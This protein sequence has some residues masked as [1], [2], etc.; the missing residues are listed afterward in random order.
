M[1]SN[2]L[3]LFSWSLVLGGMNTVRI[4]VDMV[5]GNRNGHGSWQ[6]PPESDPDYQSLSCTYGLMILSQQVILN[7]CQMGQGWRYRPQESWDRINHVA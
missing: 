1:V 5:T 6:S 4:E 7:F 3:P 2:A